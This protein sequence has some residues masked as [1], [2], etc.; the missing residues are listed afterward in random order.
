MAE[1]Q[2]KDEAESSKARPEEISTEE[3]TIRR[4]EHLLEKGVDSDGIDEL[5]KSDERRLTELRRQE[6]ARHAGH[7]AAIMAMQERIR[8]VDE[9]HHTMTAEI[10]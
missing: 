9:R 10:I 3:K 5:E 1:R 2:L 7:T 4:K 6:E 8:I